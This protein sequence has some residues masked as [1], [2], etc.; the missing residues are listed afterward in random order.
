MIVY[1]VFAGLMGVGMLVA[2]VLGERRRKTEG[3]RPPKYEASS[4]TGSS[5]VV[6]N[7]RGEGNGYYAPRD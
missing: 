4:G 6:E 7:G 3:G 5:P 1:S 2:S